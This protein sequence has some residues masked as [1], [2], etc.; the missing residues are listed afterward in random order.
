VDH[1]EP[2]SVLSRA[3]SDPVQADLLVVGTRGKGAHHGVPLGSTSHGLEDRVTVPLLI[4][5]R[6]ATA[7]ASA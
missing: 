2:C 6:P 3:E 1:G 7:P 5:S 4:V